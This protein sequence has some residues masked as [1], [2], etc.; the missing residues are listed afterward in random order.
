MLQIYLFLL[1]IVMS[2]AILFAFLPKRVMKQIGEFAR[3]PPF[4]V[5]P[6]FEYMARSLC[7]LCTLIGIACL[8]LALHT[9][10]CI[11]LIRF[12][13]LCCCPL[14]VLA[15]VLHRRRGEQAEA[16]SRLREYVDLYPEDLKARIDLLKLLFDLEDYSA[17]VGETSRIR[18]EFPDLEERDLYVYLLSNYLRGLSEISRKRYDSALE[19]LNRISREAAGQTGLTAIWPYTLYYQGWAYY[20]SGKYERARDRVTLLMETEPSHPLLPQALF[21]SGWASFSLADYRGSSQYF[22]RL[23]KMNTPESDKS[24]FLQARSLVNLRDLDTA[25]VLFKSHYTTRPNSSFA[26]DALFEYAGI[27]A[28]LGKTAEAADAYV[29]LANTYPRS[30]LAEESDRPRAQ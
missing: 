1:G 18:Q 26:D 7:I 25:A 4:E 10:A 22:A 17:I 29:K 14:V 21:L 6:I 19:A 12:I 20:R 16:V 27:Q 11:D 8:Y 2:A 15:V 28:E 24:A 23:A 9:T 3:L 13:G 5:T 30:P